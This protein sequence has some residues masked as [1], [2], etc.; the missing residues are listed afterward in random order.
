MVEVRS[1]SYHDSIT[2]MRASQRLT[3]EP[4]VEQAL[5]AMGT[6]VNLD[7]MAG[8]GF[9]EVDAGPNDLVVA[10]RAEGES[11]ARSALL[12]VDSILAGLAD[13]HGR[14]HRPG[15]P[16]TAHATLRETARSGVNI[17]LVSVPGEHAFV[18]AM[19]ALENGLSVMVFS[20]NVPVRHEV[21][22]KDEATRRDLLLLGPDAGTSLIGGVGL[23]FS[24]VVRP[25]PVGVVSASGTGAQQLMCLLDA[26]GVG[27]S[28][29][30]GVGGRDLSAEVG[31]RGAVQA[32]RVLDADPETRAVVIVSKR[33]SPGAE[34]RVRAAA[35]RMR[36]PVRYALVGA[37]YQD[38]SAVTAAVLRD[39]GVEHPR[40]PELPIEQRSPVTGQLLRGLFAG[41]TLCQEAV[42]I[43]SSVLGRV[44][45][46]VPLRPDWSL[47]AEAARTGGLRWPACHAMVDFGA[48]EF[49]AGRMHPMVDATLRLQALRTAAADANTGVI[50]LDVV[51]GFA[52]DPDPAAQL[53]PAIREAHDLACRRG[54]RIATVVSLCGTEADRQCWS[55]Q[56]L[57]LHEA[58]ASVYL[59]N[60][61]A[62]RRAAAFLEGTGT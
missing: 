28:N 37:G 51:I 11:Q 61:A 32:L 1:G 2:L 46:N 45:S 25:G 49:T 62:A 8:M 21:R 35:A 53:A 47:P 13:G 4:G 5:V 3:T 57:A 58:G 40:W 55:R 23:G 56:A 36:K 10:V 54:D 17:A 22:L 12:A 16:D 30:L 20:D 29:V 41:G 59:S 43:G 24:N 7:L 26:A 33:P 18:T 52:A 50:L 27:V 15:G 60:A 38:L 19:D 34:E 48:D 31:G 44:V 6:R 14:P 9:G 42:A 39:A